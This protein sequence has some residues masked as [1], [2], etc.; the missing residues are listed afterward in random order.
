MKRAV[1]F[2]ALVLG[3]AVLKLAG[4]LLC[5]IAFGL[6]VAALSAP[7]VQWLARHRVPVMLGALLV[8][9]LDMAVIAGLA[10]VLVAASSDL[11]SELP[12]LLAVAE[13][14]LERLTAKLPAFLAPLDI[15]KP[16]PEALSGL[17]TS[18]AEV[19][20]FITVALLVIF[21]ALLELDDASSRLKSA[22]PG[23][24]RYIT[25]V[26]RVLADVRGYL[27]V[28]LLTSLL[29][30]VSTW[31]TFQ[32][33]GLPMA[34]LF[35]V[36]MFMLH[37]IPNLGALV[38]VVAS[39]IIGATTHGLGAG[40]GASFVLL[41]MSGLIGNLLEPMLLSRTLSLSPLG[42]VL[43]L[44]LWGWLWGAMGALLSLPLMIM[45]KVALEQTSLKWV[46]ELL[47]HEPKE[48]PPHPL[49][50]KLRHAR[51]QVAH[52]RPSGH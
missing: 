3:L 13:R 9:L 32:L 24:M 46:G 5:P 44:L 42:V 36:G 35:S 6:I 1:G 43:G 33:F 23:V 10:S 29:L 19:A 40:L 39:F 47:G 30:A 12:K 18:F 2:I 15:I 16:S 25:T 50:V 38:V 21:F 48:H 14:E 22:T 51:G 11:K 49:L 28:K 37:F 7:M 27:R 52:P 4:P 8:L 20:S 45:L 41:L 26:E 17:A 34:I 31:V